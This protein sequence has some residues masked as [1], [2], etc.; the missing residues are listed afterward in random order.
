MNWN[1]KWWTADGV[2][3]V[4]RKVSFVDQRVIK[5]KLISGRF[6]RIKKGGGLVKGKF[7]EKI[8]DEDGEEVTWHQTKARD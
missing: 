8:K 7:F 6:F 3:F 1:A 2:K 4:C 5:K